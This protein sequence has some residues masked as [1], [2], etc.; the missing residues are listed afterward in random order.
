[1]EAQGIENWEIR[2]LITEYLEANVQ[3]M[4]ELM[5]WLPDPVMDHEARRAKFPQ[6]DN[7]ALCPTSDVTGW[8]LKDV[9]PSAS[10]HRATDTGSVQVSSRD[11]WEES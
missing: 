6:R 10:G 5:T 7:R 9:L 11:R 2:D 8:L 1:M 3:G 4:R